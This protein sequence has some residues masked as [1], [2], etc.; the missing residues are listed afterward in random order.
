MSTAAKAAKWTTTSSS[1]MSPSFT[2]YSAAVHTAGVRVIAT[3]I[4]AGATG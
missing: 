3:G 2:F 1:A 4:T